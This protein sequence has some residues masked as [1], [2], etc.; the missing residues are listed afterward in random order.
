LYAT[1]GSV[2]EVNRPTRRELYATDSGH[3]KDVRNWW[4]V[5]EGRVRTE[6]V[7]VLPPALD[8]DLGYAGV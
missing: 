8:H 4:Y 2:L 7:V 3:T 6:G 1:L 5:A